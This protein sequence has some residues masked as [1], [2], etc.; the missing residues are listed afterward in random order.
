[1][2]VEI[3]VRYE[4]KLRCRAVHGPSGS[5]LL[6]DAPADNHG[7]GEAFSPTDLVAASL[8]ACML[9]I[10][11][12]VA[13]RDRIDISGM[14]VHVVKEMI[15]KPKRRISKLTLRFTMPGG[16]RL[17]EEQ[18]TKLK[19][20]TQHCPVHGSIHPDIELDIRFD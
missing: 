16:S 4:G 11:G 10:M 19:R 12:I 5:E 17:S 6:T 7:R 3:D 2:T 18:L 1:M 9:T 13:E 15:Q 20:A 8:G 14:K